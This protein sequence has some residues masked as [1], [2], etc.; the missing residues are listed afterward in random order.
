MAP[1]LLNPV[2]AQVAARHAA[3][4]EPQRLAAML[5][6]TLTELAELAGLHR[7]SLSRNPHSPE[8]QGKLGLLTTI[9]A[10]AAEVGGGID[11]AVLWF[12]HQ[13]IAALGHARPADLAAAGEAKAVLHYLDALEHGAYA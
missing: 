9:L 2:L 12:R 8:I 13:P 7:S 10:R 1:A 4:V 5:G 6:I 3:A 11:K